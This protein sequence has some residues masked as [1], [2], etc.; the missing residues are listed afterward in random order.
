MSQLGGD[1]TGIQQVGSRIATKK[2][3]MHKATLNPE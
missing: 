1:A 3:I 2:A